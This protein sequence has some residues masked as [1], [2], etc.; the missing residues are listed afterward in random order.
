V[1]RPVGSEPDQRVALAE[2]AP[3]RYAA[4]LRLPDPGQWQFDVVA[5]RGDEEFVLGRRVVV[6]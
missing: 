2:V 3:G 4:A 5:T 6:K 1:W